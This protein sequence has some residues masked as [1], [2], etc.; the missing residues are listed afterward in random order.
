MANWPYSLGLEGV[1]EGDE[2]VGGAEVFVEFDEVGS[3]RETEVETVVFKVKG[4]VPSELEPFKTGISYIRFREEVVVG[5][6]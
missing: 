1:A 4:G 3:V 5:L 6:G 2:E